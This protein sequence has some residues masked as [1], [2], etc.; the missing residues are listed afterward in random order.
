ME[1]ALQQML[2]YDHNNI[3]IKFWIFWSCLFLCLLLAVALQSLT[4]P[5]N[6]M[7]W[8]KLSTCKFNTLHIKSY[9]CNFWR[10]GIR[11]QMPSNLPQ[12]HIK[13]ASAQNSSNNIRVS[14][15]MA[16]LQYLTLWGSSLKQKVWGLTE[17]KDIWNLGKTFM[18][19]P[20][21]EDVDWLQIFLSARSSTSTLKCN[22]I[23]LEKNR[24]H[25]AKNWGTPLPAM[26]GYNSLWVKH[27]LY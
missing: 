1:E 4:N 5:G 18:D 26:I 8:D 7:N 14:I 24:T 3:G 19:S 23:G 15:L 6:N 16:N 22:Q 2:F 12:L 21:G 17:A 10:G 9:I 20:L 11:E 25:G 27:G 13:D